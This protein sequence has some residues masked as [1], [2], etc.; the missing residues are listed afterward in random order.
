[1]NDDILIRSY[2]ARD[3]ETVREISCD[4]AERGNPVETYFKDREVTADF[5]TSYYTEYEPISAWV[6]EYQGRI[7]G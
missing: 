1:M 4:T 7:V 6:A 3:R 5:L 2:E